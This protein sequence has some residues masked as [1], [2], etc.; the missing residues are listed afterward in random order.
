MRVL[1]TG[2]EPFG[3]DAVN[4]S[5]EAV[6]ALAEGW[7]DPT[8]HLVTAILPVTFAGAPAALAAAI[9]EHRPDAVVCVGEAGGRAAVTPERYAVNERA[10]RIPDNDGATPAGPIDSGPERL[11]SRIDV[12]RVATAIAAA[13][14]PAH[15]SEDAG[16]F[17]CNAV[18]RAALTG[19]AGPAGFVH[20]PTVRE[21]GTATVGAETDEAATAAVSALTTADLVTAL[22]A[23]VR[24]LT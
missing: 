15:V 1:V 19:F 20:V 6:T 8:I 7:N 11:E 18:F 24:A 10:A 17:V 12:E 9:G 2:F 3:G 4:A 5:G 16:R 23:A 13:G 14:L 21:T 22:D